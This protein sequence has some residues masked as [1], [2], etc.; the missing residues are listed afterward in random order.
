MLKANRYYNIF[1]RDCTS[2]FSVFLSIMSQ[3]KFIIISTCEAFAQSLQTVECLL[4]LILER[5]FITI[6]S[7]LIEL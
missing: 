1:D 6:I 2:H 5:K 4:S 7:L 3:I